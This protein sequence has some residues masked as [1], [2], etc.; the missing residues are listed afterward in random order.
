MGFPNASTGGLQNSLALSRFS[1]SEEHATRRAT[2]SLC[3]S[4]S[5][6]Q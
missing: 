4:E 6:V 1:A 2:S 5:D 3:R